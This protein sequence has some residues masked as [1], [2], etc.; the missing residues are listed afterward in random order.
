[1]FFARGERLLKIVH[2]GE[3]NGCGRSVFLCLV[4][5]AFY[6]YNTPASE[7][8]IEINSL[9]YDY[10]THP[11]KHSAVADPIHKLCADSC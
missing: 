4:T 5:T 2:F 9:A 8:N 7:F 10:T 6:D 1:M 3:Q 11:D